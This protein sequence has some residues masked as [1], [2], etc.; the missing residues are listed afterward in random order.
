MYTTWKSTCPPPGP[1]G[2]PG[3][4]PTG[5]PTA[6]D[7]L[8]MQLDSPTIFTP[9]FAGPTLP[10]LAMP[11]LPTITNAEPFIIAGMNITSFDISDSS[12]TANSTSPFIGTSS[13][14]S[15]DED[16]IEPGTVIEIE[17]PS[18]T[19]VWETDE[20]LTKWIAESSVDDFR[21]P[22]FC[23]VGLVVTSLL[24]VIL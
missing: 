9:S 2:P 3:T 23:R 18:E 8:S 19:T 15:T 20:Y 24:L 14:T 17:S 1:P 5:F 4:N 22:F 21:K 13:Y 7:S 11:T 12:A 16:Y 10:L 6:Y